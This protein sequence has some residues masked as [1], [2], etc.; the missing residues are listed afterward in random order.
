MTTREIAMENEILRGLVGSTAHGINITGQDDRDEM[1][2][3]IEPPENVCGLK[4]I[5]HYIFRTQPEGVRSGPGDLDLTMYSLRKFCHLAAQGNPSVLI[6]LWLP[7]YLSQSLIGAE[8]ISMRDC[9]VSRDAGARF[10]GYLVAQKKALKG[11]KT[12]KVSRPDLVAKY[13]YDTKFA[14]HA[15]RLGFEGI[16]YLTE[17]RLTLPVAEPNLTTLRAIRHG[18]K[19]LAEVLEIIDGTEAELARHVE[20]CRWEADFDAINAFMVRAHHDHWATRFSSR[21]ERSAV[22]G[23][24]A[25]RVCQ[26]GPTT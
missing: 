3:F 4:P 7:E 6:L 20:L 19:S 14:M 11:E 15:A 23:E 26:P 10:L 5:E 8:M 21:V 2:V 24:T 22:D 17:G 1:G 25:V 18:E 13:G 16:E 12:K 9:F